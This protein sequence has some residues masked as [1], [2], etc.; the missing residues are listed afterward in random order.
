MQEV[1]ESCGK[2][3][4]FFFQ[5]GG[6]D[7]SAQARD[8]RVSLK[9]FCGANMQNCPPTLAVARAWAGESTRRTFTVRGCGMESVQYDWSGL[10]GRLWNFDTA[11]GAL[12]GAAAF[13]DIV[14]KL[15]VCEDF[16]FQA[17]EGPPLPNDGSADLFATP[18]HRKLCAVVT[19]SSP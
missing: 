17:G 6:S 11:T 7:I 3:G 1:H 2:E 14:E 8:T 10:L 5:P 15:D 9:A 19:V 18:N 16:S 12:I 13:N 4:S